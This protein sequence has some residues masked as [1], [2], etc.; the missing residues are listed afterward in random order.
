MTSHL[1]NI[2]LHNNFYMHNHGHICNKKDGELALTV[3]SFYILY[4]I[5]PTT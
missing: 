1:N 5:F 4:S 2:I 3:L